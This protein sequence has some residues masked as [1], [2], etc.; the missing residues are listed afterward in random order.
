MFDG[1]LVHETPIRAADLGAIGRCMAGHADPTP[2]ARSE[3]A[4][5]LQAVV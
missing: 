1:R 5:S 2:V 4:A 3:S